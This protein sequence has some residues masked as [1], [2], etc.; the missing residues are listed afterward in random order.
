LALIVPPSRRFCRPSR[1]LYAPALCA[2][3]QA[4]QSEPRASASG[5]V[6]SRRTGKRVTQ[7]ERLKDSSRGQ[8]RA[9]GG[10]AHGLVSAVFDSTLKGS[11]TR[12]QRRH[13]S[14]MNAANMPAP[15]SGRLPHTT[16]HPTLHERRFTRLAS[17]LS[18][19]PS[20]R[21]FVAPPLPSSFILRPAKRRPLFP[22]DRSYP[23]AD[24]SAPKLFI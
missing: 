21:R 5:R 2:F 8:A 23:L 14:G 24:R 22:P 20:L 19:A 1:A 13:A 17:S 18:V 4:P 11:K 3:A 9:R 16:R 7:P 10:A 6:A 15:A 12:S